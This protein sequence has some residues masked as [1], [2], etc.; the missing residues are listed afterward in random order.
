MRTRGATY[1][2]GHHRAWREELVLKRTRRECTRLLHRWCRNSKSK[3]E[4]FG[5]AYAWTESL[6][7]EGAVD[8]ATPWVGERRCENEVPSGNEA[9]DSFVSWCSYDSR[10]INCIRPDCVYMYVYGFLWSSDQCK[11]VYHTKFNHLVRFLGQWMDYC[12][13]GRYYF[14]E[15]VF[16]QLLPSNKT[17][18]IPWHLFTDISR[19]PSLPYPLTHPRE[20]YQ[21]YRSFFRLWQLKTGCAGYQNKCRHNQCICQGL[22]ITSRVL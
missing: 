12:G 18:L 3:T 21:E 13:F 19:L 22:Y 11:F 9:P 16:Q 14:K 10:E 4:R 2:R 15:V 1:G 7:Y 6:K 5:S 17:S 20:S 8:N